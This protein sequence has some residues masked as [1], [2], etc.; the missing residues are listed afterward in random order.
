M[1][2]GVSPE[3]EKKFARL[4]NILGWLVFFIAIFVYYSTVESTASFW[5]CSENLSVYW[6][7]EIGHSPGEPFLQL[8]QHVISLLAGGD[9]HKAAPVMN[10]AA[11][12]FSA[13]TI[14]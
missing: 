5:D 13:F 7:L 4:N 6:K 2:N 10:H 14:L 12:T 1:T 9:V 11:S 8:V 3:L